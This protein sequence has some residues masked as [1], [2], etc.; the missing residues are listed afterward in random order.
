MWF[1]EDLETGCLHTSDVQTADASAR[2]HRLAACF[3]DPRTDSGSF[4][5]KKLR[6]QTNP[7]F[8]LERAIAKGSSVCLSVCHNREPRLRGSRYRNTSHTV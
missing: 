2:G 3:L 6:T 8:L 1:G 4:A 7:D 5:H